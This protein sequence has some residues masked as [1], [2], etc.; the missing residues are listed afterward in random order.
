MK[1]SIPYVKEREEIVEGK[2]IVETDT[3]SLPTGKHQALVHVFMRIS[4]RK[5]LRD[6]ANEANR[7]QVMLQTAAHSQIFS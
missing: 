6:N 5:D 7:R 1:S 4:L 2:V 3:F